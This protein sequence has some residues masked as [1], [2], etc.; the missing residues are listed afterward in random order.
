M[1]FSASR[2][3]VKDTEGIYCILAALMS[4]G[5]DCPGQGKVN[6]V[7]WEGS[8]LSIFVSW[9]GV[10]V[11]MCTTAAALEKIYRGNHPPGSLYTMI[12]S[13]NIIY[14]RY[15]FHSKECCYLPH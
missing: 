12:I 13:F 7:G 8:F 1:A 2:E 4:M 9:C 11:R 3:F 10:C 6:H 15:L 14:L 5:T